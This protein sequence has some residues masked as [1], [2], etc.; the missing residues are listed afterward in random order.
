[1]S[2]SASTF[3]NGDS[4]FAAP[5]E[6]SSSMYSFVG[7]PANGGPLNLCAGSP[8]HGYESVFSLIIVLLLSCCPTN[9]AD[10]IVPR[11]IIRPPVNRVIVRRFR[12]NV[13]VEF[14]KG[15]ESKFNSSAAIIHV[16]RICDALASSF[17]LAVAIVFSG[18]RKSVGDTS[19]SRGFG[20]KAATAFSV[21]A[22]SLVPI[23]FNYFI[24]IAIALK[25]PFTCSGITNSQNPVEFFPS[26]VNKIMD[27]RMF[28][29][30]N[31]RTCVKS[32]SSH[33]WVS[34][35]SM[36]VRVGQGVSALFQ[37]AIIQELRP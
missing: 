9:I 37:P 22:G 12:P 26:K 16:S 3:W 19:I 36:V 7:K 30:N 29:K 8:L 23:G 31:F 1:M 27:T 5:T 25:K 11:F 24:A 6:L 20:M 35:D 18:F 32:L 2:A 4:A 17:S 33:H 28:C 10:F 13:A 34:Y 15:F 14:V 21:S